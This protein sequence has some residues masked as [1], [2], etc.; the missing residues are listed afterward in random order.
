[1]AQVREIESSQGAPDSQ[2]SYDPITEA[3]LAALEAIADV[4]FEETKPQTQHKIRLTLQRLGV[5]D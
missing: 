2:T 1:M 3:R 5:V 4:L